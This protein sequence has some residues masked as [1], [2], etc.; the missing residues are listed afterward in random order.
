[1]AINEDIWGDST[2]WIDV[3]HGT[4]KTAA[5]SNWG[6]VLDETIPLNN[7][8]D[9]SPCYC[10]A[11]G[12]FYVCRPVVFFT[13]QETKPLYP[14]YTINNWFFVH[15]KQQPGNT[16]THKGRFTDNPPNN[17]FSEWTT[18]ELADYL[19]DYRVKTVFN[20]KLNQLLFVPHVFCQATNSIGATVEKFQLGEYLTNQKT[21]YPY[22]TGVSMIPLYNSSSTDVPTWA[23][24]IDNSDYSFYAM[25][26]SKFSDAFSSTSSGV[27]TSS[28]SLW[29]NEITVM[30]LVGGA[31]MTIENSFYFRSFPIGCDPDIT[32]YIYNET[33][34]QVKYC[35]Q[36]NEDLLNEIYKQL[37]FFGVFFVGD[38]AQDPIGSHLELIDNNVFL[39]T[40]VDGLTYGDYTRG[41]ENAEQPQFTWDDT[42]D[43]EYD[44]SVPPKVDPNNYNV[45][46][47]NNYPWLSSP[48]RLYSIN[49][50][51]V[52]TIIG[53]YNALWQ[54]YY[55]NNVGT[56]ENQKPPTE[57]NYDEFLTIS[58]IDTIISLKL[59]PYDTAEGTT[60]VGVRLG[61]YLAGINAYPA[62]KFDILDFGTVNIFAYFGAAVEGDW[63][64]RETKYTLY[65]PFCG[66]L[67]LD[68]AFY[69]G[70]TVGLQYW[71]DQI[72]GA[73]TAA[74]YMNDSRGVQ[75]F[76]DTISGVCAVD[77]P[78]T[79]LDQATIQSQ[80]FNA[81]Q[82]LKIANVNA[83]SGILNSVLSVGA[84]AAKGDALTGATSFLGGVG[85]FIKSN[86]GVE[87]A[88]YNLTH[89]KTAPRQIGSASPLSAM[90][91]DWTP[92]II[93]SKP[94]DPLSKTS[95]K[96][97]SETKGVACIIPGKI[98][99]RKGFIQMQNVKLQ[100]PEAATAAMT[101]TEAEM[102]KSLLS[103]GIF[104]K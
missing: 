56:G 20:L 12:D 101:Q 4:S 5:L 55:T 46:M 35:R 82:Q 94:V 87:S 15:Y 47:K 57:F 1:M 13:D 67:E 8:V 65:A 78:I 37:A 98:G 52:S 9:N 10:G 42:S 86:A 39:G 63:R 36:F 27:F 91:G 85:N 66:T 74:L 7:L 76:P 99:S 80:I 11:V 62:K 97:F 28:Y 3:L 81:N 88:Q 32:H 95:F 71:I 83:A 38:G 54:C 23:L 100:A 79:G 104:I 96:T 72:T 89:N 24:A 33:H 90:L 45:P 103:S 16:D 43:S 30:G 22:I 58:P 64:D 75:I 26:N 34:T 69:M 48:N 40:I 60:P 14:E 92:R 29:S 25:H 51:N 31:A 68:P 6:L 50:T 61:R 53:L 49:S 19:S 44:P 41:E 17:R 73:C 59:F 2:S 70:K 77:V 18:P 84:A 21:T 102:I 93:I